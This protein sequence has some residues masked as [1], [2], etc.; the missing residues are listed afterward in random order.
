MKIVHLP[1]YAIN[2]YQSN[3]AAAQRELGHDVLEGGGGGNFLRTALAEWKADLLHFHW[4]H[5][6]TLR[7]S[8][9]GSLLRSLRFL[10]EALILRLS[11]TRLAWTIHNLENHAGLHTG[12]ERFVSILF[13]RLC[14]VCFAHSEEAARLARKRFLLRRKRIAVIPHPSYVGLYPD[15]VTSE[16]ARKELGV[17]PDRFVYLFL[18]RINAYKG[19]FDLIAAFRELPGKPV[20]LVA[21]VPEDPDTLDRLQAEARDLPGLRVWPE[22]I[23]DERLQVF[24]RAAD[25]AVYPYRGILTSGAVVLGMSF[26]SFLVVPDFPTIRETV[27]P[28]GGLFFVPGDPDSLKATLLDAQRVDPA[29]GG[30][31]NL[32]WARRWS[33]ARVA[34]STVEAILRR[35]LKGDTKTEATPG[36]APEK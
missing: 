5:P 29:K 11:G 28:G 7:R 13:A 9:A 36:I 26:G 22:R 34:E 3:L 18:G 8:T 12:I 27:A 19:V 20:L 30:A 25:V 24:F 2:P 31:R 33:L 6:Y 10:I 16:E 35:A 21:G 14:V 23:P 4:L 1:S 32:E 15:S 17:D